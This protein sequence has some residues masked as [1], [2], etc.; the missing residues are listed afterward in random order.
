MIVQINKQKNFHTAHCPKPLC[1]HSTFCLL[2]CYKTETKAKWKK[3]FL[4]VALKKV[5]T[6]GQL[7]SYGKVHFGFKKTLAKR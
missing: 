1:T 3:H 2:K 4:L 6:T 7:V 5:A